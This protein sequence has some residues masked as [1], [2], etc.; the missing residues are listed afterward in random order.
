MSV[1][2]GVDVKDVD[3]GRGEAEILD[4]RS[5]HMPWVE[6]QERHYEPK[7]VCRSQRNDQGIEDLVLDDIYPVKLIRCQFRLDGFDGDKDR[8]KHQ[9]ARERLIEASCLGKFPTYTMMK[10]QK[11]TIDI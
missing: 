7:K 3:I 9:V 8:G 2:E 4:E 6:E 5:E 1:A 10:T 11:Y